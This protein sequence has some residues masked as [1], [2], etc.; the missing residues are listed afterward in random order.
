MNAN[1]KF[2]QIIMCVVLA[3]SLFY[4]SS[5]MAERVLSTGYE[6]G[7]ILKSEEE[8]QLEL[9]LGGSFQANYSYYG[10]PERA[11]NRFDIR[12][13]RLIFGGRLTRWFRFG[14]EYEFQGNE[15]NNLVDAY[16]EWILDAHALRIGQFKSP[17]SL[18][19]QTKDKVICFAERS[20]GY[21]LGPKRD[22]GLMLHGSLFQE[23]I[24]YGIGLFNGDGDDGSSRGNEHDAPELALRIVGQPFKRTSLGL[25]E[26]LQ[27]GGSATYAQ[28][29]LANID[30]KVKSTGMAGTNRNVYVL[31]HDTKFGVLQDVDTRRRWSLEAAWVWNCLA[32]QAEYMTLQYRGLEAV[33]GP[34]REAEFSSWYASILWCLTGEQPVLSDGVMKQIY[35]HNFFN[36]DEGTYGAVLGALRYDHFSGA[37]D[38]ITEGAFVSV[39]EADAISLA[40][41]WILFPMY[42]IILDYTYTDF[43]DPL[44]VRVNPDGKIDYVNKESAVTFSFCMDF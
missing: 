33:T 30:L 26:N 17:F 25:L 23:D 3:V 2:F 19:W 44:K 38:W 35:P 18:E 27:F 16:G 43:S 40:F 39:R 32:A 6:E 24:A 20:M 13:A 10:E 4:S 36:P 7:A 41:N 14:M 15:T 28:V 1:P 42:K 9:L 12:R 34:S 5:A 29:D 21:C 8:K 37:E 11:D 31:G 22:L